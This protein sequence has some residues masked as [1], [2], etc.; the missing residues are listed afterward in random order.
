MIRVRQPYKPPKRQQ[1]VEA[2]LHTGELVV[3]LEQTIALNKHL[4]K[5]STQPLPPKLLKDLR[6]LITTVPML[7]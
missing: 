4:F 1:A 6:R 7:K 5:H 3:P 2:V